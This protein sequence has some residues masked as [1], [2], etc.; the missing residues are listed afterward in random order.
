MNLTDFIHRWKS[1]GGSERANYGLFLSQLCRV[2]DVPEPDPSST[3][4]ACNSYV[5][6][7]GVTEHQSEG[8]TTTKRIDLYR[9]GSFVLE[10]K[11]GVEAEAEVEAKLL[12][13]TRRKQGHGKRGTKGWDKF[14]LRAREQAQRYVQLLPASDGRPPFIL[15]MDVGHAIEVYSEFTRTGGD[16]RPFPA[17]GKHRIMLEDLEDEEIR[18]RLRAIW[19]DPMSLD[20]SREAAKVTSEIARLL[21]EAS[22]QM[23]GRIDAEGR[24]LTPERV[25][26][27][28]MRMIF[29]MFAED[30]E[31][32]PKGKFTELLKELES[33]PTTFSDVLEELWQKMEHGGVSAGLRSPIRHFNGGL[34][35]NAEVLPITEEELQLLAQAAS[36]D[37]AQVE[38][39][40]FGTLVERALN[41][42]ERHKLGAHYTPRAYVERLV[43]RTII[44][45]LRRDWGSVQVA[46]QR[47]LDDVEE[48]IE[49]KIINKAR[50]AARK[51][52]ERFLASLQDIHIL[53]P[54]C[55]TGNFLYVAMELVKSL[56]NEVARTLEDLGGI[57]PLIG[58][59]PRQFLGIEI[60]PRA[61]KVADLVLWI[62]YLQIYAREHGKASAP[63]EPILQAYHNIENQDAILDYTE[64][65]PRFDKHGNPVTRWDGVTVM[66]DPSTGREIPDPKALRQDV[67][68]LQPKKAKWPAA[69]F[70][71][72][73]PPFI[74]AGPMRSTLGDGYVETIRKLY[75][76]DVPKSAD[77]VMFWWAR[78]AKQMADGNRLRRFGFVTTNS[79]KQ[80]F[81]RRV[82]E[83]FMNK[84]NN[85]SIAYAVPDHPWVDAAD[86]AAVR[87][88]MTVMRKGKGTGV[89]NV[90]L[91]DGEMEEG[92]YEVVTTTSLGVIH[93]D[94]SIGANLVSTV[95]LSAMDKV[96][97][98]GVKLHGKEFII[99]QD[100][101]EQL[102]LGLVEGVDT[103]LPEFRNG[104]DM[105]GK[106]RSLRV[107]DLFGLEIEEVRVKFPEVYEYVLLNVKPKRDINSQKSRRK[108]WWLFGSNNP[109]MRRSILGLSRYIVSVKT[110]KHRLFQFLDTHI[111]PESKLI[112][113]GSDDA[114]VLGVLSSSIHTNWALMQGSQL[115]VGNHPT[116]VVTRCFETFPFPEATP[117]HQEAIRAVAEALDAHRK[118]QLKLHEKL[119]MTDMYNAL[120]A[121]R[122]GKVLEG[123]LKKAH[124]DGLVATLRQLHDELD[125]LV[126]KSYGWPANLS[127][128]EVLEK[129][130]QL[131]LERAAEEKE[132]LVRYLRPEYQNPNGKTTGAQQLALD[133][134]G[135][136]TSVESVVW[137][138]SMPEQISAVRD[139]LLTAE[140][141]LTKKEIARGFKGA[142]VGKISPLLDSLVGL[143]LIQAG[144]EQGSE[145]QFWA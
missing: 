95:F 140:Q 25:S 35:E 62:G 29:T 111:L 6:E 23:E 86:G 127:E 18:K 11:Q 59:S 64:T 144:Q 56:E 107:I 68:Y 10:A 4:E 89:L 60:N 121:V 72:G 129:L 97:S 80:T 31:L 138:K 41:K 39:S 8:G 83:S 53:D 106:L 36:F 141:P 2:L 55:G 142:S 42:D 66:T 3:D 44:E 13:S 109:G 57:A 110:A 130:V 82:L 76:K 30:V 115:G 99:T 119:T 16:Y 136:V 132:G 50:L 102:G 117:E 51:E 94:L 1:S 77:F 46:I 96:C 84:E 116:Y 69:D 9:K 48:E 125:T 134:V 67:I 98:E 92:G 100:K 28:L 37:W 70:I 114:Y 124:D 91:N 105:T 15:V 21:A 85:L 133:V 5:F 26:A 54:A 103:C 52:A 34:F 32:L 131:N 90:V 61:A 81:N 63:P 19:L 79:I 71:V 108:N 74:G 49:E 122:A 45:P 113:F 78:A 137:P 139:Y 65:E 40:I 128:N 104:N 75:K 101:A 118:R 123:K 58:V 47:M 126:A 120:E 112:V 7:K 87:I 145:V 24:E 33:D 14:M 43:N 27:Y 38:P 22:R 93:P 17:P 143:G 12:G 135:D 20:P 88:A 73:N